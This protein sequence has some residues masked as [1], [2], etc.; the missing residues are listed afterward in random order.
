MVI[1]VGSH[2]VDGVQIAV[3]KNKCLYDIIHIFFKWE[4]GLQKRGGI[5]G[6]GKW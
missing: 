3:N 1:Q 5:H 2:L 4:G 6:C